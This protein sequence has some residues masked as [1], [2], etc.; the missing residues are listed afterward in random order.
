[1]A[2]SDLLTVPPNTITGNPPPPDVNA[3]S[4]STPPHYPNVLILNAA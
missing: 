3:Y 2:Y 4:P 1:M